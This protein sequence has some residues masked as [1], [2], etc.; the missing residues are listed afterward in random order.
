MSTHLSP[1]KILILIGGY[2]RDVERENDNIG[3]I[4]YEIIILFIAFYSNDSNAYPIGNNLYDS[5]DKK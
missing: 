5:K 4:P 1:Y 2:I 3:K